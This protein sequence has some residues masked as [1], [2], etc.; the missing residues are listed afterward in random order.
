MDLGLILH[1]WFSHPVIGGDQESRST[2][3]GEIIEQ[4]DFRLDM[5]S[6]CAFLDNRKL[7]LSPDEFDLL[8]FLLTNHKK[9]ITTRTVLST[10]TPRGSS[11][12][13]LNFM[14]TLL[15]L[16]EKLLAASSVEYLRTEPWVLYSFDASGVDRP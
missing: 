15:S 2:R 5:N 14:R 9:L 7:S 6:R 13:K 4:G 16:H 1:D 12:R 10:S 11:V 8:H 3:K